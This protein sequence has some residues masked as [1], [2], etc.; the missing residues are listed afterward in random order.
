MN[1]CADRILLL[2]ALVDGELDAGHALEVERH[3][4]GCP[5]CAGELRRLH[6]LKA[7][8][9]DEG[10]GHAAP[11]AL[12]GRVLAALDAE[13]RASVPAPARAP[14]RVRAVETW[15]AS[16]AIGAIAASLFLTVLAPTQTASLPSELVDAQVRSLQAQHL[17][18]VATSD[19]HTVK[20]WFNGK[21]A[22]APP[23]V[24]L[25]A[26]GY[27]LAGGRMEH[28]HGR[29]A[30][31]LVFHRRAHV[32]NVFVWPGEGPKAAEA[33][34][35]DGYTLIH[36]SHGGLSFWAVSDVDPPDLEAFQRAF[37]AAT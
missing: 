2:N 35:R 15:I 7:A 4:E 37:A 33:I 23:V 11:E 26:E 8:L 27:P 30:A 32:I 13:D 22:F 18:D 1:A 17:V 12:R 14:R 31:V 34:H 20:P 3:A 36:W 29:D 19:R 21:V 25:A 6:A 24:D 9:R 28:V 5:G 10:L 16:G